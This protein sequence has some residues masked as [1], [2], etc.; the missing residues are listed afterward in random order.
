MAT[1]VTNRQ[2]RGGRTLSCERAQLLKYKIHQSGRTFWFLIRG[3]PYPCGREAL[4]LD[5]ASPSNGQQRRS[6]GAQLLRDE[7]L[8]RITQFFKE[9]HK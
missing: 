6:F 5:A 2:W 7:L 4:K 8:S 9:I 3:V 1:D